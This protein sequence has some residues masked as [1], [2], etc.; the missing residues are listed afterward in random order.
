MGKALK[1]RLVVPDFVLSSG[2]LRAYHTARDV[3][4]L[5]GFKG[6]ISVSD[7]LYF[8]GTAAIQKLIQ[9]TPEKVVTLFVFFHNPDINEIAIDLL[10][11]DVN[12]VPTL[13][14]VFTE[15]EERYWHNWTYEKAVL[16]G[17]LRP[18]SFR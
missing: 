5:T 10:G 14:C 11:L 8:D 7:R 2:A 9:S 15:C 16:N 18:K 6:A 3:C 13:G 12:N 1:E 17:F 4:A